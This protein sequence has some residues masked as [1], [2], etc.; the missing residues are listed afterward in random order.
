MIT[1]IN[2]NGE[3]RFLEQALDDGIA[4]LIEAKNYMTYQEKREREG[5]GLSTGLR[6]GYQQT[7]I[8]ARIM[9]S[10]AWLLGYKAIAAGELSN[11]QLV[12]AGWE[13]GGAE[14]CIDESGHDNEAFPKG[15]RQLLE[16]SHSYYMRVA[17]LEAMM[18]SSRKSS[19]AKKTEAPTGFT[20]LYIISSDVEHPVAQRA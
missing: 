14:E 13:L 3:S 19:A 12:E 9:H 6:I 4:L 10:L 17:R 2:F 11:D 5:C 15:L 1:T 20:G 8:T 16:R 7:R 18:K